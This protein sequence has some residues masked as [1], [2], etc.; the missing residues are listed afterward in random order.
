[1]ITSTQCKMARAA[2]G[3]STKALAK[4]AHVGSNTV[5]RFENGKPANTS[6]LALLKQA[7]ETGGLAFID[8][9]ETGGVGV[10]FR[11]ACARIGF[12][13]TSA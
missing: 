10:R 1:M 4:Q 5:A 7:F 13:L 11:S 6:T 8:A 12:S 3:W 9:D 2:L